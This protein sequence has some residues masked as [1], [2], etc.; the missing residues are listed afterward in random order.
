LFGKS[1]CGK[2]RL[3]ETLM[4]SM[5][6]HYHF[7]D[8]NDFTRTNLRNLLVNYKRFPV[9]FDD[10]E[11]KRFDAHA[12]DVIKDEQFML[13]E[14]PGFV[15]SMNA[16]NHA[17]SSEVRKRCLM[18][19][20]NASLP[21]HTEEAKALFNSV[22]AIQKGLGTALYRRYVE[23]LLEQFGASEPPNDLL[24]ASS[25]LLSDLLSTFG[26]G[27]TPAWC[28][29]VQIG[30]YQERKYEN[31]KAELRKL[32]ETNPGAWTIRRREVVLK[33]ESWEAH[34]LR[35]EIPDWLLKEGSKGGNIVLDR[36]TLED[37][38]GRKFRWRWRI[39]IRT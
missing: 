23:R 33:V 25:S 22:R 26:G 3:I 13:E 32:Y 4:G 9:V 18:V 27:P 35:K 6:G 10:V 36:P 2:T 39:G 31:V 38:M 16:D 12:T 5:F 34:G 14:Y 28:A 37:F 7:L 17:F 24:R 19:Y 11:K 20:T 1:N 15:L 21:D 8:K 29:P 30:A